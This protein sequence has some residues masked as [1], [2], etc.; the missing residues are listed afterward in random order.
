MKNIFFSL[1]LLCLAFPRAGAQE[2]KCENLKPKIKSLKVMTMLPVKRD[3]IWLEG[4][5]GS[6]F[7][8]SC[9][10]DGL[11]TGEAEYQQKTLVSKKRFVHKT[12][13]E[14]ETVCKNI[15]SEEKVDSS[16]GEDSR[17]AFEDFCRENLKKDFDAVM[18]HDAVA[19]PGASGA[20]NLIKQVFRFYNS[21]GLPAEDRQFDAYMGL[22]ARIE[23]KYS[24]KNELA[25]KT[26]YGP[27]GGKLKQEVYSFDKKANTRS[28]SVFNEHG[29]LTEKTVYEHRKDG[30]LSREV[31]T[32]YNAGEQMLSKSE[33]Y[34]DEK[35]APLR[36][37]VYEGSEN[38][39]YEYRYTYKSDK[40]GNWT[41]EWKTR[42]LTYGDKRL[43]DKSAAPRIVKRE[44]TYY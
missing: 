40:N 37:S 33:I 38:P 15:K 36:E 3:K 44:I 39:A 13:K 20:E 29:Q 12:R 8:T 35:G 31:R 5:P 22:E 14:I 23:Y 32:E 10:S 43:E 41:E 11:K 9:D 4:V 26:E 18:V 16:F 6:V 7:Q 34:C 19:A 28:V 17:S 25:E 21:K 27:D 2:L 42:F 24:G 30:T 1:S